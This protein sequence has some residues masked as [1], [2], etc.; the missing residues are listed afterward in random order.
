MR[1]REHNISPDYFFVIILFNKLNEN[2][3]LPNQ[4]ISTLLYDSELK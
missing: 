2:F 3:S 4:N 1:A